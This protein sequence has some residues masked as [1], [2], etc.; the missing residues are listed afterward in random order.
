M[1]Y[2]VDRLPP[3]A[4]LIKA[5]DHSSD[6]ERKE[7]EHFGDSLDGER[8][9]PPPDAEAAPQE[10]EPAVVVDAHHGTATGLSGVAAYQAAAHHAQMALSQRRNTRVD[11]PNEIPRYRPQ[12]VVPGGYRH[13]DPDDDH[14][15]VNLAT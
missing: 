4:P 10:D 9:H 11:D 1:S 14:H 12:N 2:M 13:H 8:R 6:H 5:A 7:R 15:E 3:P